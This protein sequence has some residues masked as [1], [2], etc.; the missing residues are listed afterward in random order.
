MLKVF[1]YDIGKSEMPRF[2]N[3]KTF[4][5]TSH[6]IANAELAGSA[7]RCKQQQPNGEDHVDVHI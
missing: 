7:V 4:G 1:F 3:E 2:G 5:K 6:E